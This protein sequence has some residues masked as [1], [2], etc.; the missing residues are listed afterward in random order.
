MDQTVVL[1]PMSCLKCNSPLPAEPDQ[2]AWVCPVCSQANYLDD[3]Q[4]LQ[5]LEIF[6]AASLPQNATG[7]PYWVADGQVSLQRET[8][9]SSK[10]KD[11]EQFW[12]QPRRFF[13][14]AYSASL[15]ALLSQATNLLFNPPAVKTGAPARFEPVTMDMKDVTAAA[16]FII[17]AIEAGRADRLKK[18]DFQLKLSR[19]VLWILPT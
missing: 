3:V 5:P 14:P 12:S 8:F 4:G 19:P 10:Y 6:Y 13:I 18:V 17:V 9:G 15:D 7:K 2:V 11:A 1:V 16:E